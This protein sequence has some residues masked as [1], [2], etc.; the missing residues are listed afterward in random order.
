MNSH[1]NVEDVP[2][3]EDAM[4][5]NKQKHDMCALKWSC[6]WAAR[7]WERMRRSL[8]RGNSEKN[9]FGDRMNGTGRK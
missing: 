4:I 2:S 6:M 3:I 8:S 7:P 1:H 5:R 9:G